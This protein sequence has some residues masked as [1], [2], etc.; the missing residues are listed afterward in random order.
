M[1]TEIPQKW[2]AG[3]PNLWRKVIF[4][5]SSVSLLL[6][7]AGS[8]DGTE[9]ELLWIYTGTGDDAEDRGLLRARQVRRHL[10]RPQQERT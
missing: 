7:K 9:L 5:H 4:Y 3:S 2:G 1:N 8:E 6:P 10:H